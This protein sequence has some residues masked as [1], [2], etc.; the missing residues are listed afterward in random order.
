MIGSFTFVCGL[1][2]VY[3]AFVHVFGPLYMKN[4]PAYKLSKIVQIYNVMQVAYNAYIVY[5]YFEHFGIRGVT[6]P[7]FDICNLVH[8]PTEELEQLLQWGMRF[9]YFNKCLDLFDTV[10][11]VLRKKNSQISFLHLIH[12]TLMVLCSWM[13][14]YYV[15]GEIGYTVGTLNAFIHV[16]MYS[17][18]YLASLGPGVQKYLWW[19]KYITKMQITQFA[20]ALLLIIGTVVARC[21]I[22]TN[23]LIMWFLNVCI[24]L[25]LF[26]NYYKQTYQVKAK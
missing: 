10:F 14:A 20:I 16:I 13:T 8:E 9:Y 18:Y 17:Y 21:D 22:D 6:F 19:K 1:L 3:H 11:M 5:L 24:F 2:L 4:R 23:F 12:H 7:F 26:I 15:K 25:V